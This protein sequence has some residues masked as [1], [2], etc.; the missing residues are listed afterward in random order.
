MNGGV[1]QGQPPVP[2]P[3]RGADQRFA[4]PTQPEPGPAAAGGAAVGRLLSPF[5]T[6]GVLKFYVASFSDEKNPTN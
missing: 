4:H 2:D 3:Q 5:I 6:P 1:L